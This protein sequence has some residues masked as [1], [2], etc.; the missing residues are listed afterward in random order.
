MD[1]DFGAQETKERKGEL[2]TLY[3]DLLDTF[4]QS[5]SMIPLPNP[6][7][8]LKRRS[9]AKRIDAL[10]KRIVQA[11]FAELKAR[12]SGT[13][14]PT[15]GT[16]SSR[17]LTSLSLQ[18][19]DELDDATAD[20]T[21]DQLKTFLLAG[22]DTTS[23][24]LQWCFYELSRSPR[25][26]NR[27]IAE[28]DAVFGPDTDPESVR[29]QLLESGGEQLKRMSYT[30]AVI[31]ELLRM[32]APAGTARMPPPGTGF[33][34]R[35]PDGKEVCL[36]G[37]VVYN[38]ANIIQRDQSVY[39]EWADLFIPE[40]WLGSSDPAVASGELGDKVKTSVPASA[41]RP[42]ERGPRN[43]IGQEMANIEA[44]VIL[45]CC[46]RR[47]DFVKVGLGEL[48]LDEKGSP[49]LNEKGQ[50]KV[51]SE[52]YSVSRPLLRLVTG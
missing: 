44:R 39:G 16:N 50:Y 40:R 34:V 17:N 14:T 10:L 48:D 26:R 35:L 37:L 38:C 21:V 4:N 51:K 7:I 45:A 11:K 41:W 1:V 52:M 33:T 8:R 20:D 46:M 24:L 29:R 28:L 18:G 22:H 3:G 27:L 12:E 2:I 13:A 47:Y 15:G 31:K 23:I 9:L 5:G 42:F 49:I 43:C 6:L 25:I 36:D 19:L 32:Y 30:S